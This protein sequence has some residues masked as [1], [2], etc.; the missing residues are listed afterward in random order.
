MNLTQQYPFPVTAIMRLLICT[1]VLS[2]SALA[3]SDN[4]TLSRLQ[5]LLGE[6]N[7]M[8]A[9]VTQLIVE[10]DGGVLEES[11]IQM[12]LKRPSG[13]YWETLTPFPQLIVTD[14]STLWNYEP[15]LEQVVIEDWKTEDGELTAQLLNGETDQLVEDYSLL[16]S[17]DGPDF[18]EFDLL[19]KDPNSVYSRVRL[20]FAAQKLDSIFVESTNGQNTVWRF[21]NVLSNITL[22]ESLFTFT[23]PAGVEVIEN[24]YKP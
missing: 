3:Q 10:S 5:L 11:T 6:M 19:P 14:G 2:S 9:E 15:D 18:T 4:E 12:H 21:N 16:L 17:A 1:L 13:F 7:T 20:S 23:P 24:S 8:S 22:D